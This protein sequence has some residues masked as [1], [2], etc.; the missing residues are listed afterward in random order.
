MMMASMIAFVFVMLAGLPWAN[1]GAKGFFGAHSG[2][3][4]GLVAQ[5]AFFF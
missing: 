2:I 1:A 4:F 3:W 5:R